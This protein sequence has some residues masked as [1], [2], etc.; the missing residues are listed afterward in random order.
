MDERIIAA[1]RFQADARTAGA[2]ARSIAVEQSVE[3]PVEAIADPAVVENILGKV[4]ELSDLGW[5]RFE[6]RIALSPA[7]L[8][9]DAGQLLNMLFGNTSLH[10]D[11]TLHDVEL[12]A[13]VAK[14][15]GGP[16]LGVDGWRDRLSARARPITMT[17]LKPQG[18]SPNALAD[19]AGALAAGGVDLIKDDHGIADQAFP[20][21]PTRCARPPAAPA[22]PRA[23]CPI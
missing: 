20:L 18:L 5:G 9:S 1:Y 13:T 7:T 8:G 12:P 15:F 11:V 22:F 10:G 4:V 3:M 6:A 19:L 21:S 16:A 17:N 2:R 23:T 14:A